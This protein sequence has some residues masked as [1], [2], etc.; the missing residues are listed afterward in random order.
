MNFSPTGDRVLIEKPVAET[1][2]AGG[3]IIPDTS[4]KKTPTQGA[5]VAL[6]DGVEE[7]PLIQ[8]GKVAMFTQSYELEMDNKEYAVVNREDILGIFKEQ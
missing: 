8:I 4:G 3:L 6:G 2:T 5:I 1:T 7:N